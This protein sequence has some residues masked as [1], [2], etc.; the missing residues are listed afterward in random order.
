MFLLFVSRLHDTL[1]CVLIYAWWYSRVDLKTVLG[2]AILPNCHKAGFVVIF[3]KIPMFYD[4]YIQYDIWYDIVSHWWIF[5]TLK[6]WFCYFSNFLSLS[7]CNLLSGQFFSSKQTFTYETTVTEHLLEQQ[8]RFY[9]VNKTKLSTDYLF[10]HAMH[11]KSNAVSFPR[12]LEYMQRF[13]N[14]STRQHLCF[15]DVQ[16]LP[17]RSVARNFTVVN[18]EHGLG[19]YM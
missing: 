11:L 1:P 12:Y 4:P 3:A 18:C 15:R 5:P 17:C 14:G 8:H 13:L 6:K 19:L 2:L 16:A 9:S 7:F 10:L